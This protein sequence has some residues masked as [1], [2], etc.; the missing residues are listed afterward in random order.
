MIAGYVVLALLVTLVGIVAG[1]GALLGAATITDQPP[2]FLLAGFLAFCVADL[3]GLLLVTRKVNTTR[4]R[5][6]LISFCAGPTLAVGAFALT[7]LIP[8]GDPQ[9]PPAPVEGQRFWELPT[10]SRIAYVRVPAEDRAPEAP[11][12][13]LHGG[14]G[15]P[16]MRGDSEYFERISR[17]GFDV[18]VYDMVGRGRSFRLA[19]PR[20]YTLERD[21][22]DLEAIHWE[23]GAE[24]VVLIGHSYGAVLAA[25]YAASHPERVEKMVLSSPGDPSPSAGG[26]SMLFRLSTQEKLGVYRLLLPP[27]PMLGY[28]LLQ[29]NPEA[30]HAFATDAEMDARF[31]HVYNRTRPALHCQ[32]KPPGPELHGL[33]FYAYYYPQSATSPPHAEFLSALTG[34]DIPALVIK[35]RCDYLS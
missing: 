6:R 9:L 16:D 4:R 28:A 15:V 7:A 11:V 23:I 21:V 2:L 5:V 1:L 35:G 27:R 30:A 32:S 26:A 14:P 29:V 18:Y 33:G 8:L 20:G 13:F 10:G 34:Q 22:A 19:D 3:L 31:D 12:I 24:K 17:D 25:A